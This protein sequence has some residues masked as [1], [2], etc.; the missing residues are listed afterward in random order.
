IMMVRANFF[1]MSTFLVHNQKIVDVRF[2]KTYFL[3][4]SLRKLYIFGGT[5]WTCYSG[6]KFFKTRISF[7]FLYFYLDRLLAVAIFVFEKYL[8]NV[9][10]LCNNFSSKYKNYKISFHK[11]QKLFK[12]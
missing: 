10:F 9:W 4:L 2:R 7:N 3:N 12:M 11:E 1:I 6:V 8:L 5:I